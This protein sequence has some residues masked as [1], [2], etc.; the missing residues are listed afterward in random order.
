M[1]ASSASLWRSSRARDEAGVT[2]GLLKEERGRP[3]GQEHW[4]GG[5]R[6]TREGRERG[7]PAGLGRTQEATQGRAQLPALGASF[8]HQP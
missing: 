3:L 2:T 8:T 7:E 1:R 5:M 6:G 4:K